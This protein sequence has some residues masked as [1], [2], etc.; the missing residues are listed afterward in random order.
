MLKQCRRKLKEQNNTD[1]MLMRV[2]VTKW[3]FA[4]ETFDR[5]HCAGALHLFPDI[6]GVLIPSTTH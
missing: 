2:N 5:I 6:Q 3:P 4:P 1:V